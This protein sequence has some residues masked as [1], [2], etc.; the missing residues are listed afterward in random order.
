MYVANLYAARLVLVSGNRAVQEILLP[1]L[2]TATGHRNCLN[3]S[4]KSAKPW[5]TSRFLGGE[6]WL[7]TNVHRIRLHLPT[8]NPHQPHLQPVCATSE[9]TV[10]EQNCF[11]TLLCSSL[12][13]LWS[14]FNLMELMDI[15][16]FSAPARDRPDGCRDWFWDSLW[17]FYKQSSMQKKR[18]S[19][20]KNPARN[21]LQSQSCQCW[22]MQ[23]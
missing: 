12:C 5:L 18:R 8:R 20:G 4:Q 11:A 19:M 2:A 15:T 14:R 16:F 23:T 6:T 13:Q 21:L 22:L 7:H 3:K 17:I 10:I 9:L 1:P